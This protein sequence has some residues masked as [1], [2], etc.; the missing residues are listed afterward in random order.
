MK[1]RQVILGPFQLAQIETLDFLTNIPDIF[2]GQPQI[3]AIDLIYNCIFQAG[4]ENIEVAIHK[5]RIEGLPKSRLIRDRTRYSSSEDFDEILLSLKNSLN[6]FMPS[7]FNENPKYKS[8]SKLINFIIDLLFALKR[9]RSII[10]LTGLPDIESPIYG[11]PPEIL[12]P[13]RNL[14]MSMETV[15]PS[16]VVPRLTVKEEYLNTYNEILNSKLYNNYTLSHGTMEISSESAARALSEIK[17]ASKKLHLEYHKLLKPKRIIA[18]LLP[19]T[20]TIVDTVFG[21][22][23]GKLSKIAISYAE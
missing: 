19:I 3:N 9:G 16:V 4:V 7:D 15:N 6:P 5:H 23:P 14:L 22:L 1:E 21:S 8:A 13:T 2:R 20:A 17:F 10:V 12:I 11:I 18:T